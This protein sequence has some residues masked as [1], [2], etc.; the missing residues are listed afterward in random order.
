METEAINKQVLEKLD[1]IQSD[2]DILK[3]NMLEEGRDLADDV[4]SEIEES[5]NRSEGEM[6]S[7][8]EMRKEFAG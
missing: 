7:H 3:E 1:R 6:I 2:I 8:E 5:K 4:V